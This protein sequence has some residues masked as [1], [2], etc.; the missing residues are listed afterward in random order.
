VEL[1]AASLLPLVDAVDPVLPAVLASHDARARLRARAAALPFV[2]F[3]LLECH[4]G[5]APGRLDLSA[6]A[7]TGP[8]A[9][10]LLDAAHIPWRD[11]FGCAETFLL[12]YDLDSPER[13]PSVF[14]GFDVRAQPELAQMLALARAL[15]PASPTRLDALRRAL[16]A[17]PD[18]VKI[19]H[20]GVMTG[21]PMSP[22]R[23]NARATSAD[24]L[25]RYAAAI[26]IRTPLVTALDRLLDDA[27]PFVRRFVLAIDLAERP[28]P[29]LGVECYS[30]PAAGDDDW[31]ALLAHLVSRAYCAQAESD[32]LRHWAGSAWS[33]RFMVPEQ[34]RRLAEF[35]EPARRGVVTRGL[36]HVKLTVEPG[37][38]P[39]AKAYLAVNRHEHGAPA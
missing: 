9:R 2:P 6:G 4:L 17:L 20:L 25:R 16:S 37:A 15:Q 38:P 10:A 12:E 29:R 8:A 30:D 1:T 3:M 11:E 23:V 39:R 34:Q 27:E 35:L 13:A 18:D 22:F 7:H 31:T 19:T 36:N 28:S 5:I 32:A 26:G 33:S 14:A 24:A 21:R